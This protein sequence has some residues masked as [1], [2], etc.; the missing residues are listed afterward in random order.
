MAGRSRDNAL[1][2]VVVVVFENRSLDNVLGHLHPRCAG[3][4]PGAIHLGQSHFQ[5]DTRIRGAKQH[6]DRGTARRS[7]AEIPPEQA[8]HIVHNFFAIQFRCCSRPPP[9]PGSEPD[10]DVRQP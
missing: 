6:R 2:H 7:T 9:G 3:T 8:L 1:D 10:P 4:G 5:W